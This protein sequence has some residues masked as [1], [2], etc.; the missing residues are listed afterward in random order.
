MPPQLALLH[1]SPLHVETFGRLLAAAAPQLPVQ[2]VVDETLLADAQRL[3]ADEPTLV[4]RVQ[5][6]M[7]AAAAAQ[8]ASL[9]VCTCSTIGAAAERMPTGGRFTAAR[10]DRA[11]AD[12]AVTRGPRI[13][14][15]AALQST[16]VPTQQ[17]IEQS[18][19]RLGRPV[20][21]ERL[22][23]PGAWAFF[24]SGDRTAYVDSVVQAVRGVVGRA[25]G[26]DG[27]LARQPA[28]VVVLAQASMAAAAEALQ[29]LAVPVLSSPSLGVQA[30][31]AHFG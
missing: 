21:I 9:V 1:T 29:D 20:Q 27:R 8:G 26:A 31:V 22:W 2:H 11:M 3:G 19:V 14:L 5:Q 12:Q 17:L 25:A 16:L 6:A 7:A 10:I 15:V 23:V 13:L 30:I 18:A 4:R 24:E 28:D